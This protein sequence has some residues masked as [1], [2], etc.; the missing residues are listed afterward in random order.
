MADDE[1]HRSAKYAE[2]RFK[3]GDTKVV[4][5]DSMKTEF[6]EDTIDIEG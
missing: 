3:D 4:R 5:I 1:A 2:I 6:K